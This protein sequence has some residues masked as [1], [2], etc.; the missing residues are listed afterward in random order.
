MRETD[1]PVTVACVDNGVVN[2]V[3]HY[4]FLMKSIVFTVCEHD[5]MAIRPSS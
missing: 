1:R 2:I 5:R 4:K 3:Q